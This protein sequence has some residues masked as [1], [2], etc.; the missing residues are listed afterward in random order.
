MLT[1]PM[2]SLLIEKSEPLSTFLSLGQNAKKYEKSEQNEI[3]FS[4][5]QSDRKV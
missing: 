2:V 5:P 4:K 1:F 3:S